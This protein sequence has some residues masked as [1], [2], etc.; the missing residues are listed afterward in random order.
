ML[1][2]QGLPHQD[3]E[4]RQRATDIALIETLLLLELLARIEHHQEIL[5][6]EVL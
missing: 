5:P 2:Q 3:T 6:L 1:L 4:Q